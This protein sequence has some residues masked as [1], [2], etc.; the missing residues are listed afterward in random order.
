MATF[1]RFLKSLENPIYSRFSLIFYALLDVHVGIV[2]VGIVVYVGIYVGI[3]IGNLGITF[4]QFVSIV[5]FAFVFIR[6][7]Y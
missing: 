3:D 6:S 7:S 5:V 4:A 2:V 1:C